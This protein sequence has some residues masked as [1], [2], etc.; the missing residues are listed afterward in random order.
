MKW[1]KHFLL[2]LGLLSVSCASTGPVIVSPDNGIDEQVTEYIAHTVQVKAECLDPLDDGWGS[3]VVVHS[4]P[5]NTYVVTAKH[6]IDDDSCTYQVLL[7]DA[8]L[9]VVGI[10]KNPQH[11]LA[12]LRVLEDPGLSDVELG[13]VVLGSEVYITGYPFDRLSGQAEFTVTRG[14]LAS[15]YGKLVR[16]TAQVLPGSS[17]GPVWSGGRLVALVTSYLHRGGIPLDG[18]YYAT[19]ATFLGTP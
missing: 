7:G 6:V 17:G 4:E 1:L 18:H 16:V 11:D 15:N 2:L 13:S 14:L 5:G 12:V 3:G 8:T 9:A 10:A 19:P